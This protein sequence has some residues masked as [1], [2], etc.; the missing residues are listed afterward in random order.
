MEPERPDAP[1]GLDMTT[2]KTRVAALRQAIATGSMTAT[3]PIRMLSGA[4]ASLLFVPVYPT[5]TAT[6]PKSGN[7]DTPIGI[8]VFRLSLS[9]TV[10]AVIAAFQPVMPGTELYV[11]DD[12]ATPGHRLIYRSAAQEA[13]AIRPAGTARSGSGFARPWTVSFRHRIVRGTPGPD[14]PG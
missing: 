3:P 9:A 13:G 10:E 5:G 1:L 11:I 12:A 6:G 2:D 7:I 14:Q 4:E 8:L